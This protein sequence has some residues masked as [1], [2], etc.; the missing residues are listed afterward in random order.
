MNLGSSLKAGWLRILQNDKQLFITIRNSNNLGKICLAL[1]VKMKSKRKRSKNVNYQ[2][3][4]II[5]DE[6]AIQE[7]ESSLTE[8]ECDLF[9]K[10]NLH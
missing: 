6:T 8:F 10:K 2:P 7:I 1:E 3:A 4:Q 5:K 9:D